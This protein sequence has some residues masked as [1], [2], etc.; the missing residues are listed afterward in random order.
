MKDRVKAELHLLLHN[1]GI[2]RVMSST[3]KHVV[4]IGY[5]LTADINN[6]L[7][8]IV[9]SKFTLR[10]DVQRITYGRHSASSGI[11]MI[12]V[13]DSRMTKRYD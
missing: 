5:I 2:G 13:Y 1:M 6:I 12:V 3:T 8:F 9:S 11:I 7:A 4:K 10:K